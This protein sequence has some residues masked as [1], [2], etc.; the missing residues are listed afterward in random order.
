MKSKGWTR[1]VYPQGSAHVAD[2][3]DAPHRPD[4]THPADSTDPTDT[5]GRADSAALPERSDRRAVG[6]VAAIAG[7]PART[8]RA[9]ESGS[10]GGRQRVALHGTHRLPVAAA[11]ARVREV[12]RGPLLLRQ[13]GAGRDLAAHQR[14]AARARARAGGACGRAKRGHHRQ[15]DGQNNRSWRGPRVGRGEKRSPAASGTFWSTRSACC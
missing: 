15:P 3:A 6:G 5:A 13:M 11:A 4:S 7:A 8:W 12:D 10:A 1:S 9:A 2:P 14:P